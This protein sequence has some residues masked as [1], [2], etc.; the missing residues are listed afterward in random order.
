MVMVVI[1]P[2]LICGFQSV[3]LQKKLRHLELQFNN[4]KQARDDLE[5]KYRYGVKHRC[6]CSG[7]AYRS[8]AHHDGFLCR[9]AAS[10]LEK[11]T[12]ELEEE[13]G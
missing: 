9:T 12:K 11:V 3:A 10:R 5:Q 8:S 1:K 4:D 2:L 13:V 7:G 6:S